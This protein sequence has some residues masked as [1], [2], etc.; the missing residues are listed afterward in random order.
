MLDRHGL[1]NLSNSKRPATK[2][3]HI[4]GLKIRVMANPVAPG[5]LGKTIGA[6]AVPMAFAVVF[7][8]LEI[9]AIDGQGK[10]PRGTCGSTRCRKCRIHLP[11]HQRPHPGGA[12][13]SPRNSAQAQRR[14]Q[15]RDPEGRDGAKLRSASCDEGDK[16]VIQQFGQA[17]VKA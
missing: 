13:P 14:R 5:H 1:P 8:A 9:K 16:D 11:T 6:N 15:G 10:P 12:G 2:L 3:D 7:T 4:S 17:G